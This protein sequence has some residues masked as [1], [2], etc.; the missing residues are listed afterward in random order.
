MLAA[1]AFAGAVDTRVTI[2]QTSGDFFGRVKAP[3]APAKCAAG[4]KVVLYKQKG[5][6][7]DPSEDKKMANDTASDTP[8]YQWNTGNTNLNHG[9]FYA[10]ATKIPG[11]KADNSKTIDRG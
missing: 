10:R 4:R 11:C 9:K 1:T 5:A 8:P 7:Q 6:T 2:D 3:D